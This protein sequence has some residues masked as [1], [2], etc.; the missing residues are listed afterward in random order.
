MGQVYDIDLE[1]YVCSNCR[2]VCCDGLANCTNCGEDT[3]CGERLCRNCKFLESV[4]ENGQ[5]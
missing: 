3:D 1:E 2:H 4:S 5:W